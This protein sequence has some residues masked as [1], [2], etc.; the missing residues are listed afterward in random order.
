MK[1]FLTLI[2]LVAAIAILFFV[3]G[4]TAD[5]PTD[6]AATSTE[7]EAMAD[8]SSAEP[9]TYNVS[10]ED[11]EVTWSAEKPLVENY[12]DRGFV[13]ISSGEITIGNESDISAGSV[14]F[15][16]AGIQAT[17]V[18]N[19]NA[20]AER[21]TGH[22]R[23]EDFFAVEEFHES[24]FVLTNATA[25]SGT[26]SYDLT[27]DLTIKGETDEISFPATVGMSDAGELVVRG[28]T[29]IDRADYNIRFGS[30]SFFDD[31]GDNLIA[32]EVEIKINLVATLAE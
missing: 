10:S 11:S 1:T 19:Q 20:G 27:G 12:V 31:L 18:A 26:N 2:G 4:N 8:L 23:S 16:V 24:S 32:D 22:L 29:T 30:D 15:D 9:G 17:E 6:D 21:L 5:A 3:F 7:S 13:P 14:T 25:A 28:E